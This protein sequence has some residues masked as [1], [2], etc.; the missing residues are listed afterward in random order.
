MGVILLLLDYYL[1]HHR[2]WQRKHS[3]YATRNDLSKKQSD[4]PAWVRKVGTKLLQSWFDVWKIRNDERH[5]ADSAEQEA[6]RLPFLHSQLEE[7]YSYRTKVMPQDQRIFHTDIATHLATEPTPDQLEQWIT[8]WQPAI[9]S[10][11]TPT[12]FQIQNEPPL[13]TV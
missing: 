8:V 11:S 9:M 3:D 13:A 2:H 10:S 4:G 1:Q 6:K 7:L 12:Q 5:G